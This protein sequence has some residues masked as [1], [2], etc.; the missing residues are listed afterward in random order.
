MYL[1]AELEGQTRVIASELKPTVMIRIAS[2]VL[3]GI[4]LIS[5]GSGPALATASAEGG[6]CT[7]GDPEPPAYYAIDLVTT[8]KV[9]GARMARGVANMT[10]RSSPFGVAVTPGGSYAYDL[11]LTVDRLRPA[12]SGHYVVWVT[13]PNLDRVHRLGVLD[14]SFQL[15]GTVEFNKFLVVISLEPGTDPDQERWSGPIVL[16]G[17]SRSGK[18]HTMAGHGPFQTEPCAVYGY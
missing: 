12:T 7:V 8:K 1:I 4:V 2:I 13:T 10:F 16:R 17:M 14:E 18:M 11:H 6:M 5:I 3:F 9:P 15:A